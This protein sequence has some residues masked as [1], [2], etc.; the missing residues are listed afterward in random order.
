M[1]EWDY[2]AAQHN[3]PRVA[4]KFDDRD[5]RWYSIVKNPPPGT[6]KVG[7]PLA[8]PHDEWVEMPFYAMALRDDFELLGVKVDPGDWPN[9][10]KPTPPVEVAA[11]V[12]KLQLL[13]ASVDRFWM[14]RALLSYR[15]EP[16]RTWTQQE[17]VFR[18]I[19]IQ[20]PTG[21]TKLLGENQ[22]RVDEAGTGSYRPIT[23]MFSAG[24]QLMI[25]CKQTNLCE[26]DS[27]LQY[28]YLELWRDGNELDLVCRREDYPCP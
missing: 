2:V 13:D 23:W 20:Q 26:R 22:Y 4:P 18:Y 16:T 14:V 1:A 7:A 10:V 19:Q 11:G 12:T 17:T 21:A 25:Q 3:K 6:L 15:H 5:G 24:D 8:L 9:G 28:Y 27:E